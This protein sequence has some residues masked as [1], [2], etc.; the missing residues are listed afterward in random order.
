MRKKQVIMGL[1]IAGLIGGQVLLTH[2]HQEDLK[3]FEDQVQ[4]VED[5]YEDRL[6][7]LE[8][9]VQTLQ[10]SLDR[11]GLIIGD[12]NTYMTN[13]LQANQDLQASVDYMG[14]RFKINETQMVQFYIDKLKDPDF[15]I[16]SEE[17]YA[18]YTAAEA[19]GRIGQPAIYPL[20]LKLD[21]QDPFE[22]QM[23]LYALLLASQEQRVKELTGGNYCKVSPFTSE[24]IE[25]EIKLARDWWQRYKENF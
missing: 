12:M 19:L 1:V 4:H 25:E 9:Q 15:A 8:V 5:Q 10:E 3:R 24:N 20:V 21:S 22:Q 23:V 2:K 18:M 13:L 11:K 16:I 7:D 17:G 14:D 6:Q